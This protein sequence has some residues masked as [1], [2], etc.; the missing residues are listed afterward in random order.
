VLLWKIKTT[1]NNTVVTKGEAD[2]KP[3]PRR[4]NSW[5]SCKLQH[6]G[7]EFDMLEYWMP[8]RWLTGAVYVCSTE[9][10]W[11]TE[12]VPGWSRVRRAGGAD[13]KRV[14]PGFLA[15]QVQL[16]SCSVSTVSKCKLQ[17]RLR[18]PSAG[19]CFTTTSVEFDSSSDCHVHLHSSTW[20]AVVQRTVSGPPGGIWMSWDSS[21]KFI[22]TAI[23]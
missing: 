18:L 9:F 12:L 20:E 23:W 2:V 15:A 14:S 7:T 13:V 4:N 5:N 3:S 19:N 10:L 6:V 11:F 8:L 21:T 17:S 16:P 1:T 22:C